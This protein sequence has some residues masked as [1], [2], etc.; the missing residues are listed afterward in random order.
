MPDQLD[1]FGAIEKAERD[2]A[3]DRAQVGMARS[4]QRA[5]RVA[6]G[7]H[8]EA[9]E[10]VRRY[11]VD[12][13]RFLAEQVRRIYPTPAGADGRC[14]GALMREA[15]RRGWIKADGWEKAVSSNL[16]PKRLWRSLVCAKESA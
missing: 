10:A 7:W 16:T 5:E 3:W 15:E 1:I 4:A 8:E 12:H 2:S 9:L 6:P 14:W 13:D 11:A